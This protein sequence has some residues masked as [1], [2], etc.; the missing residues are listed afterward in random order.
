M[1]LVKTMVLIHFCV[2]R[3]KP[4]LTLW[5]RVLKM[6]M[7]E[8]FKKYPFEGILLKETQKKVA[9]YSLKRPILEEKKVAGH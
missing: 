8:I 4:N 9:C 6:A 1:V 5:E 3:K 7:I 2:K